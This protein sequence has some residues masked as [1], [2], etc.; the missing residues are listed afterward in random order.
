MSDNQTDAPLF[1]IIMVCSPA[2][3]T[4]TR[5]QRSERMRLVKS[6]GTTPELLVKR[7]LKSMRLKFNTHDA[8]VPGS[9]DFVFRR[10]GKVIFV[11][12]CFWHRHA[13]CHNGRRLPKSRLDFWKIKLDKNRRRD[14]RILRQLNRLGWSYLVIWECQLNPPERIEKRIR[15]FLKKRGTN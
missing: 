5:A 6:R 8:S 13:S 1:D 2:M 7:L 3:D 15:V 12:G 14:L 11:H 10:Q 4:L 9:P